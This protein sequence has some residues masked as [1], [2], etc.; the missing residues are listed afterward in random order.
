MQD[1]VVGKMIRADTLVTGCEAGVCLVIG[2][3]VPELW[4][5]LPISAIFQFQMWDCIRDYRSYR[6]WKTR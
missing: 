6:E 3:A 5:F 2:I 4:F 1:G